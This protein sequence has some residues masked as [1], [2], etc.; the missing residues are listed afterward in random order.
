MTFFPFLVLF[1]VFFFPLEQT[2]V[3]SLYTLQ[4][5]IHFW[6]IYYFVIDLHCPSCC[7]YFIPNP[8]VKRLWTHP[9]KTPPPFRPSA[10]P[11]GCSV[12][13]REGVTQK[14]LSG[15]LPVRELRLEPNLLYS[16]P[17]LALSPNLLI[18]WLFLS[19]AYLLAKLRC[20][21]ATTLPQLSFFFFYSLALSLLPYCLF[22]SVRMSFCS[23]AEF[24]FF[25]FS[26]SCSFCLYLFAFLIFI[27]SHL[28]IYLVS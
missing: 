7:G 24:F 15:V 3:L 9:L 14:N 8:I 2:F 12:G 21:W 11:L 1:I 10:P 6:F 17:L 25:Y 23:D 18:V 26:F 16:L 5:F 19:V 22:F 28:F 27:T 4:C 20:S 13:T